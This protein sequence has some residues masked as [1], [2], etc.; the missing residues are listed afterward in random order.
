M[1]KKYLY[2]KQVSLYGKQVSLYGKQVS[3]YSK[4]V[5]LYGK[6]VSICIPKGGNN[7]RSVQF[8][9]H[10]LSTSTIPSECQRQ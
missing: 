9:E 3:L 10:F 1:V 7:G 8:Q 4:Q 6:Q 5:Y 2:S